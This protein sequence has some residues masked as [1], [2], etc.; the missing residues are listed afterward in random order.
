LFGDFRAFAAAS[1]ARKRSE[2]LQCVAP[3]GGCRQALRP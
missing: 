1:Q 3:R 2:C